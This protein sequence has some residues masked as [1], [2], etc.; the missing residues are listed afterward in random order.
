MFNYEPRLCLL[1]AAC[2]VIKQN[3]SKGGYETINP[4]FEMER[5]S[6]L[7]DDHFAALEN[8]LPPSEANDY[9]GRGGA[10]AIAEQNPFPPPAVVVFSSGDVVSSSEGRQGKVIKVEYGVQ[11]LVEYEDGRQPRTQWCQVRAL[12]LTGRGLVTPPWETGCPQA[13][14]S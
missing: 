1:C 5:D 6:L 12:H 14:C 11:V 2:V 8:S 4:G 7:Q 13:G 10:A 9:A 3:N